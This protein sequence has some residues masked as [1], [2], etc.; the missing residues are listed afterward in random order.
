MQYPVL[1]LLTI[2]AALKTG[3]CWCEMGIGNPMVRQHSSVCQSVQ[4]LLSSI[5]VE[6]EQPAPA[7][8]RRTVLG[9]GVVE[10]FLVD[11]H[12]QQIGPKAVRIPVNRG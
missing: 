9:H 12:G 6:V 1:E 3:D 2:I 8:H 4:A 11:E 10:R 5:M 7:V